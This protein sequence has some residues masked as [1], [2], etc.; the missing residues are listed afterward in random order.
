MMRSPTSQGTDRCDNC[1]KTLNLRDKN[2]NF[3]IP[4]FK[5]IFVQDGRSY[6][7]Y[8]RKCYIDWERR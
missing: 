5:V 1:G 3:V 7:I 2:G 4:P 8:C 6:L